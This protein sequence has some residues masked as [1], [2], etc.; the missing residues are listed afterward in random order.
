MEKQGRPITIRMEEFK[1][2]LN[3]AVTNSELPAYLLEILLGQYLQG[4]SLVAQKEYAQDR[5][6]WERIQQEK[7]ESKTE[8]R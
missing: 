2:D 5:E 1:E 6:A 4:I 8:R 7:A 3:C